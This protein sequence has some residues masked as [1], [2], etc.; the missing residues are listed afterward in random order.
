MLIELLRVFFYI[1]ILFK[2][3]N[4]SHHQPHTMYQR[5][6]SHSTS[7]STPRS[8]TSSNSYSSIGLEPDSTPY[9]GL[10]PARVVTNQDVPIGLKMHTRSPRE[11]LE[12]KAEM[13]RDGK[14]SVK[15]VDENDNGDEAVVEGEI[16]MKLFYLNMIHQLREGGSLGQPDEVTTLVLRIKDTEKK[17]EEAK[18]LIKLGEEQEKDLEWLVTM[19]KHKQA[20]LEMVLISSKEIQARTVLNWQARLISCQTQ[21]VD[22]QARLQSPPVPGVTGQ[23]TSCTQFSNLFCLSGQ[24]AQMCKG[25]QGSKWIVDRLVGGQ[26]PER[27]LVKSELK[28]PQDLTKHM[29]NNNCRKVILALA[30]V[31]GKAREELLM[32]TKVD[33]DTILGME[34]GR[35]FVKHI[36]EGE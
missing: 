6:S 15:K 23:A 10:R 12:K 29:T 24:L 4:P 27:S 30:E 19:A 21:L 7:S 32:Q 28:L 33:I 31:D 18:R 1:Y 8:S 13:E 16:R 3:Q 36:V 20:S 34:G 11:I 25:E 17:V 14:A 5:L 9:R 26:E 22:A 35:E 2:F